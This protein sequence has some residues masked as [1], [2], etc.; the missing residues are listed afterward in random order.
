MTAAFGVG[1]FFYSMGCLLVGA[2]IAYYIINR[3]SR[4][5]RENEAYLKEL[6]RKL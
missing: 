6:K 4:E 3:K 1:M 2:I 5:E